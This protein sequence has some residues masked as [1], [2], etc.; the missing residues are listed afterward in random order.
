M[1][2]C[3]LFPAG[4][5]F[6]FGCSI[7]NQPGC[8]YLNIRLFWFFPCLY[9]GRST[10]TA[11]GNKNWGLAILQNEII[12]VNLQPRDCRQ[13]KLLVL[14]PLVFFRSSLENI[15]CFY[16]FRGSACR[17]YL[18]NASVIGNHHRRSRHQTLIRAFLPCPRCVGKRLPTIR[19]D[20]LRL[21]SQ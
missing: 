5:I 13:L 17:P 16:I 6:R 1:T 9:R 21:R 15:P 12:W 14:V 19:E 10:Q 8:K 18:L 11:L 20:N 4:G 2:L 7:W 3:G